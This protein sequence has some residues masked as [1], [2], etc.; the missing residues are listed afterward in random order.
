MTSQPKTTPFRLAPLFD[1]IPEE[2]RALSQWVCWKFQPDPKGGKPR[3]VPVDPKDCGNASSTAPATCYGGLDLGS[4]QD[5][6]SLALYFPRTGSVLS[7]CWLPAEPSLFEREKTDKAPYPVWRQQGHI[8][9]FPGRSTD[10]LAV[11]YKLAELC[12]RYDV[13]GVAYDRWGISVLEKLMAGYWPYQ[14]RRANVGVSQVQ[15]GRHFKSVQDSAPYRWPP[16][17]NEL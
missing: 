17:Q 14:R 10:R 6:T 9:T 3:K 2:L 8:E 5:L 12:N 13:Q 4:T 15:P 11:A 16:G 7:Y 1:N